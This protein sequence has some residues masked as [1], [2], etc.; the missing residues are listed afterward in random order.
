MSRATFLSAPEKVETGFK[1]ILN[2]FFEVT[3]I[4]GFHY[5]QKNQTCR[6]AR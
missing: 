5:L 6:V 4:N 2:A 1:R 3:K